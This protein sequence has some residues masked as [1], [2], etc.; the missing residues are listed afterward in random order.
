[1][2]IFAEPFIAFFAMSS[3]SPIKVEDLIDEDLKRFAIFDNFWQ[4]DKICDF[5]WI[6]ASVAKF[7]IKSCAKFT[8]NSVFMVQ[9]D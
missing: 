4:L 8:I 5:H 7:S 1:M 3:V 6:D 9:S 2:T